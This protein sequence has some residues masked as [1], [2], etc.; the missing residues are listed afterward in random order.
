M[1]FKFL[2]ANCAPL[3]SVRDVTGS[4]QRVAGEVLSRGWR[5][6]SGAR[7]PLITKTVQPIW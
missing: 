6:V 4:I 5:Q 1:I 7:L 2:S 3:V